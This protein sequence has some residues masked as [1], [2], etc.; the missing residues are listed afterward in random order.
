MPFVDW[1]Q[2][3]ENPFFVPN[4][5]IVPEL[6][7][8]MDALRRDGDSVGARIEVVASQVPVGLGEP[9]FDKL[10]ADIAYALMGI[11]AV[12]VCRSAPASTASRSAAAS[13]ATN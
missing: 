4:A 7:T 10:D 12:R 1:S 3:G 5:D 11:N 2:V 9:L 6:E 8:Y 13:T